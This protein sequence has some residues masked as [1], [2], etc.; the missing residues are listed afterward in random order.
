M[1]KSKIQ[2]LV[3]DGFLRTDIYSVEEQFKFGHYDLIDCMREDGWHRVATYRWKGAL[4]F[5]PLHPSHDHLAFGYVDGCFHPMLITDRFKVD[6]G[7]DGTLQG[8]VKYRHITLRD[9]VHPN[10]RSFLVPTGR[11]KVEG[12]KT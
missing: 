3:K 10:Y 6:E 4:V 8:S 7:P 9:D 1:L 2:Q 5:V 11:S 12:P